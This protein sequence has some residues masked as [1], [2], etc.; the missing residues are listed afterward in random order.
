MLN[1]ICEDASRSDMV[2]QDKK[3]GV[4]DPGLLGQYKVYA[5]FRVQNTKHRCQSP[6]LTG[7]SVKRKDVKD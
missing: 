5:G 4:R 6:V 7:S 2:R 1:R 3:Q